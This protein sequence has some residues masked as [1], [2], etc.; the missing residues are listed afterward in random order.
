M[1][2]RCFLTT[3]HPQSPKQ[4]NKTKQ[5]QKKHSQTFTITRN[6]LK[7]ITDLNVKC[8]TIQLE[9]K[10]GRSLGGLDM[11]VP[12]YIQHQRHNP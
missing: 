11:V 4:T 6:K 12:F 7:M 5:Q 1:E 9:D 10:V 2:K 8:E 3:G